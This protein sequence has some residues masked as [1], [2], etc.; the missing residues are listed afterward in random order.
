MLCLPCCSSSPFSW[1]TVCLVGSTTSPLDWPQVDRCCWSSRGSRGQRSSATCS[2][3]TEA[4]SSCTCSTAT[5]PRWRT[6]PPSA[7]AVEAE[8][9]TTVS[10]YVGLTPA[11]LQDTSILL[12]WEL[13]FFLV[14]RFRISVNLWGRTGSLT[15]Q[16]LPIILRGSC[17]LRGPSLSW[18][19][20]LDTGQWSSP[21]RPSS[22]C[23]QWVSGVQ[24]CWSCSRFHSDLVQ[25]ICLVGPHHYHPLCASSSFPPLGGSFS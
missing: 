17:Q 23:R 3:A 1:L 14:V 13:S 25:N 21:R 7:R 15:F 19:A 5:A 22:T 12:K 2:A 20:T 8:W 11:T 6:R 16:S 24:R 18:N 10:L 4:R 9:P